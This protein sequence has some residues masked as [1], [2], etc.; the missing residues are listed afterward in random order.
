MKGYLFATVAIGLAAVFA[1]HVIW[2][3]Q[4]DAAA[5]VTAGELS[6]DQIK[7]PLL[8]E[9]N[10]GQSADK[11]KF[12]SRGPGYGLFL[13][14]DGA[15]LKL[16]SPGKDRF[17]V[18][19]MKVVDA[20]AEAKVEG[21]DEQ[22]GK[23]NY[24]LGDDP[25]KWIS[26]VPNF[27]R[28]KYDNVYDGIDLVYYGNGTK[29]EYD[30]VVA[31]TS[32][33]KRIAL[34]FEG[35]DNIRVAENGDLELAVADGVL[36]QHAPVVYQE[37]DDG[38]RI[39]VD[40]RYVF[41][42]DDEVGFQIGE[43]DPS[44]EL[45]IDP[46]LSY[47]TYLGSREYE[48]SNG[49]A[50]D[51]VGNA[52]VTG[53]TIPPTFPTTP[54]SVSPTVG[55]TDLMPFVAKFN[56]TGTALVYSTYLGGAG[57]GIAVD[58]AGF[59]YTTGWPYPNFFSTTPGALNM[60]RG[61]IGITKL[62]PQGNQRIYAA[63]FGSNGT[64]DVRD[65]AIDTQGNAYVT[66][67]TSCGLAACD[68]PIVN[69]PQPN[70]AGGG[71]A[72]VSKLNSTGSAL[73]YSTYLGGSSGEEA[74]DI[75]VD[76]A[77]NAYVTGNTFSFTFPTTPGAFDQTF[78]CPQPPFCNPDAFV[79][80][81]PP[82]GSAFGYSTY[83]GG[84]G[85]E[86]GWS[87]AVDNAG[88]AYAAGQ[89][90][91]RFAGFPD[92]GFPTTANAF[93]RFGSIDGYVTKLNPTGSALVYS[94][95]LGGGDGSGCFTERI[96]GIDVDRIGNAYVVGMTD[97]NTFPVVN[98]LQSTPTSFREE[99]FLTKLNPTGS[100]LAYSTYLGG[101]RYDE[102]YA[103]A[104]DSSGSAY[105]TGTT[106][107]DFQ[108]IT[109]GAFDTTWNCGNVCEHP[110]DIFVIKVT[111]RIG[112]GTRFDFDGDGRAD[113]G[114]FRPSDRTW[115]M[116]N[117]A[118]GF[119]AM[120]FGLSTDEITP[121]DYDGDG[122]TDVSV[123]RNGTWYLRASENGTVRTIQF[124]ATGDIPVPADYTGDGRAEVAIYRAGVWWIL[125]LSTGQVRAFSYGTASD[126]PVPADYDGD[127]KADAAVY[128]DGQW[129]INRSAQG[130]VVVDFGIASDVTVPA[131][132]DGDGKA[133]PAVFRSGIW[134]I[135]AST[136]GYFGAPFGQAGDIP[137]PADYDGDGKADLT[138]YRNGIWYSVGT[139]GQAM[140]VQFG[141]VGDEPVPTAFVR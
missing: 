64:D 41:K 48:Y 72:F 141:V 119:S 60:G 97:C 21:V 129:Y 135:L 25:D 20:D 96:R 65:I 140:T 24:L 16:R 120:Q 3:L 131:D 42:S 47:G 124:G 4:S 117:S 130:D 2:N 34:K 32:D 69:A 93:K 105:V 80:K 11:V 15:T 112:G 63:R 92:E 52:Y 81:I 37:S 107:G 38:G 137:A 53:Y 44:K 101:P 27:A 102:G 94:T 104:V 1:P 9:E 22:P 19:N 31:P 66:G 36:R 58:A 113:V 106:S 10:R 40:S 122:K 84:R 98:A 95:L 46:V 123:F 26:D 83:L 86:R 108:Q 28:V 57:E 73:V 89:T 76:P 54:G 103:V 132:Y 59:A 62:N 35:A 110:D 91:G 12:I 74:W 50:V 14:G 114:V 77:G 115:Y 125:D 118:S 61:G 79:T 7:T 88:H 18:L 8:F 87:I 133:D 23:T 85:S 6:Q 43:Y 49:I 121:A 51:A 109:A 128:R 67:L 39:A 33:P 90:D 136:Q 30:F 111:E 13:T 71:D 126:R 99:A 56:P 75:D 127:G 29:L 100:S 68:F 78:N 70:Y 116:N 5:P 138:V 134:H 139:R 45:V 17:T 55:S 82:T